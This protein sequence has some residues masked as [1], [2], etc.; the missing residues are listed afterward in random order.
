MAYN[1]FL[2]F[3][4]PFF[5]FPGGSGSWLIYTMIP[6]ALHTLDEM[7]ATRPLRTYTSFEYM[8]QSRLI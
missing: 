7:E 6:F 5:S 4:S 8:C 1:M 2:G 3:I